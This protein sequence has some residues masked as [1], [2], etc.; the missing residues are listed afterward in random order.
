VRRDDV[1]DSYAWDTQPH[2]PHP[3]I[4]LR[5]DNVALAVSQVALEF[6]FYNTA[7][8][9]GLATKSKASL[10]K[11]AKEVQGILAEERVLDARQ[12][13][14]RGWRRRLRDCY[15]RHFGTSGLERNNISLCALVRPSHG[16][17]IQP[18]GYWALPTDL[19]VDNTAAGLLLTGD[20]TLKG[21]EA[22]ALQQHV[23]DWR[24]QGLGVV[25]V[26]HHGSG[27][28]WAAGN[29]TLFPSGVA[30]VNCVP[31]E[32]KRGLHPHASVLADLGSSVVCRADYE[33][34]VHRAY[35]FD[36]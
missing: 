27:H 32:C 30:F 5:P 15:R 16:T 18:C 23:R 13:P 26:P 9:N 14:R 35:R 28:S 10:A 24:W 11:V 36:V 3:P 1:D 31:T 21:A 4:Y 22:R 17:A 7:L 19:A 25:Q 33:R 8:P 6:T 2:A 29:A 34:A 12:K 20:L